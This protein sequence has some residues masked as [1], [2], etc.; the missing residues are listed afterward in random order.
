MF[1]ATPLTYRYSLFLRHTARLFTQYFCC[2]WGIDLTVTTN[3][4]SER[5]MRFATI[6]IGFWRCWSTRKVIY[7]PMR[8][9][10]QIKSSLSSPFPWWSAPHAVGSHLAHR[11][12]CRNFQ[13][14]S[15]TCCIPPSKSFWRWLLCQLWHGIPAFCWSVW[16]GMGFCCGPGKVKFWWGDLGNGYNSEDLWWEWW[17]QL[18]RTNDFMLRG[19]CPCAEEDCLVFQKACQVRWFWSD[20]RCQWF[21]FSNC[22]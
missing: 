3:F 16:C 11:D 15:P 19:F 4:S 6:E 7:F 9:I 21:L 10:Y 1:S 22:G 8:K 18:P 12:I 13:W 14:I 2:F 20:V 5:M 17:V